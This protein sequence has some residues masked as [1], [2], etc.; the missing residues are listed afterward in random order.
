[1]TGV[2]TL[3]RAVVKSPPKAHGWSPV[4]QVADGPGPSTP[5]GSTPRTDEQFRDDALSAFVPSA[6]E[7]RL[8]ALC[9]EVLSGV[10]DVVHDTVP[11]LLGRPARTLQQLAFDD[12]AAWA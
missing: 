7:K 11:R 5:R 10:T 8:T 1:M 3:F 9:A 12:K 2:L 6:H 4:V